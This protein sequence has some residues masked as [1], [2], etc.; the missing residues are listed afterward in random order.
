MASFNKVILLGNL[1]REVEM[2]Y[3]PKGTPIANFGLAINRVWKS[4]DGTKK[5]DVCFVDCKCFGQSAENLA[6]FT[7]K[8]HPLHVEGRLDLEEWEDKESK[9]KRSKI[10]VVV[11]GFQLIKPKDKE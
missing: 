3:T 1:T 2:R 9:Q 11:E 10:T 5:E 8:G 6:K 7:K 4:E